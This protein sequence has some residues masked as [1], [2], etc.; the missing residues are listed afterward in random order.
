MLPLIHTTV[1]YYNCPVY[2][3]CC[4]P[5]C[6]QHNSMCFYKSGQWILAQVMQVDMCNVYSVN[7]GTACELPP[8]SQSVW[9]CWQMCVWLIS[10]YNLYTGS[11]INITSHKIV[12]QNHL[13]YLASFLVLFSVICGYVILTLN[14]TADAGIVIMRTFSSWTVKVARVS[15]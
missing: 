10:K 6:V 5:N 15:R 11:Q 2:P 9:Y 8:H 4:P 3:I 14:I 13:I 7:K 12:W 1:L